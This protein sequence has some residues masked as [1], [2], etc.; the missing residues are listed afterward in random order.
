MTKDKQEDRRDEPRVM[1][2]AEFVHPFD[3]SEDFR[4]RFGVVVFRAWNGFRCQDAR[5][6]RSSEKDTNVPLFP[7]RLESL[8]S[9]LFKQRL[10]TRQRNTIEICRP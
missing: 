2:R 10:S 3:I 9:I 1:P 6:E 5:F 4:R 8:Q 7:K